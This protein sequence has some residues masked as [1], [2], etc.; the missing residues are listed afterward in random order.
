MSLSLLW[1]QSDSVLECLGRCF[2]RKKLVWRETGQALFF[3]MGRLETLGVRRGIQSWGEKKVCVWT[4]WR[5]WSVKHLRW[6]IQ[7]CLLSDPLGREKGVLSVA[8]WQSPPEAMSKRGQDALE[9]FTCTDCWSYDE[10]WW[11]TC[12]LPRMFS[13]PWSSQLRNLMALSFQ[14]T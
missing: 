7:T 8:N 14:P 10:T 1:L 4:K 2:G 12:E 5:M 6:W 3:S 9:I 13:S 11:Q